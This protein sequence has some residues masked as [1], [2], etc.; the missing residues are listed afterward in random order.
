MGIEKLIRKDLIAFGGYSAA[1]S[2]E[3]LD[4]KIDVATRDIVKLDANENPYG[5]SPRVQKALARYKQYNIYPDDGQ[6]RLRK[7]LSDYA[8]IDSKYIVAGSGSNQL[9]DLLVR[10]LVAKGDE[11]INCTPTFG[12]YSF[13]TRLCGGTL[14]EVPRRDDFSIDIGKVKSVI[15]PKTKII[16]IAN[17][18]NPTATLTGRKDVQALLD[19]GVPVVVDEAY[20]EFSQKT[21]IPLVKKYD[22]LIVLRTFSKWAGLAGLRVGY[23]LFP[24]QIA[25]FILRIKIPYNVNV[26]ALVAV[27]ESLKDVD[28]LMASVDKIIAEREC[29]FT[30]LKKI[31]WLKPYPSEANFILCDVL[32]GNAKK[33][34][35]QLQSKGILVRYFDQTRVKNCI[36]ISVGK[37]EHTDALIKALRQIGGK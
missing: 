12:I 16:F 19:T 14:V 36:R 25:D 33:L 7:M 31:K 28:Y 13:S 32:K 3:T 10:L 8:G 24:P 15:T 21:V 35:Q 34:F 26:A 17:P 27:E 22:N 29:L 37:P 6:E 5:C 2:P 4:G 18:N 11:V 23:G 9:I 30:E 1:T 20:Y